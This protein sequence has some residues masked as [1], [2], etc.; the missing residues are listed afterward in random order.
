LIAEFEDL[1]YGVPPCDNV[2]ATLVQEVDIVPQ[3]E[4]RK[5]GLRCG[6]LLYDWRHFLT[7]HAHKVVLNLSDI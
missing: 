5:L 1:A 6:I 3:N 7:E 2:D 4:M